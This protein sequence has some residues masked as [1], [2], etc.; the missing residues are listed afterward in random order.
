MSTR[1]ADGKR[2]EAH[3]R[4]L[5]PLAYAERRELDGRSAIAAHGVELEALARIAAGE[6]TAWDALAAEVLAGKCFGAGRAVGEEGDV[7]ACPGW[8]AVAIA[9]FEGWAMASRAG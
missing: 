5:I 9:G 6:Q 1:D 3:A 7:G 2:R 4:G 8:R